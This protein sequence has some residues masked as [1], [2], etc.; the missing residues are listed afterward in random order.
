MRHSARRPHVVVRA[1]AKVNLF[2]EVLGKRPDGFHAIATLLVAIRRY[3]TLDFKEE[4]SGAIHLSCNRSD[5]STG[6]DNLVVRAARLLQERSG[7]KRGCRIRLTKRIPL[8]AGLAGGSSDAAATLQGLDQLWKLGW[9]RND[10]ERLGAELGSDVPF[11]FHLPAAWCTGR[12]EI[13]KPV[14]LPRP[15][16]LVLL[17]PEFGCS[18]ATVY[19]HAEISAKPR[20]GADILNAVQKGDPRAIG[21]QLFN[22]LQPAAEKIA[23]TLTEYW[24][25]LLA[26]KPAGALMSGSG[27]SLFAVCRD[28]LEANR[29]AG[30]LRRQARG[31]YAVFV[32]R[33]CSAQRPPKASEVNGD[34]GSRGPPGR[35]APSD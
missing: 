26:L 18:T 16:D 15:L 33:S 23:P 29:I 25:R 27:S 19:R 10:L 17:C 20:D 14:T 35:G 12:G 8:A 34:F 13:V 21:R 31:E 30:A 32:V 24:Q 3:D 28:R 6:P 11:F 22:R 7:C 2:L 9:N 4:T 1:P 5:L